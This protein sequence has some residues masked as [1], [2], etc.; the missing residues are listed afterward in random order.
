MIRVAIVDDQPLLL[1]GFTMILQSEPDIEI[2]GDASTG[3]EAIKLASDQRP[4][5]MLMD[6]RMP[7]LDGIAATERIMTQPEAPAIL[8]LTTFDSDE[9]VYGSLRAGA[10]GFLLKDTPADELIAAIR[11]VAEGEALLAPSI[12][13]RLIA[14]FASRHEAKAHPGMNDLTERETEVLLH[15]AKG[16]S[17]QEIADALFLGETT[18]KTHVGRVL[19]KLAV[20]D[21]VQAVVAAY[22]SG[23]VQPGDI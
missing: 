18:V 2:V 6:I 4:D 9:Y 5:V 10:S 13:R 17:N 3:L 19:M 15:M 8:V 20:R 12:T 21:R 7:D 11:I 14:D 22:E 23:L 16:M 1:A